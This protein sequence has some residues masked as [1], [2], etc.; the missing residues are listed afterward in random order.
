ME[1]ACHQVDH[2]V[3]KTSSVSQFSIILILLATTFA[4]VSVI[5][6]TQAHL[7]SKI[8]LILSI[9]FGSLAL[10]KLTCSVAASFP[11]PI[12]SFVLWTH[13]MVFEI[14]TFLFIL[15]WIHLLRFYKNYDCPVGTPNGKPILLI[16]GYCNDGTVWAY[17]RN[18]LAK[19]DLGPLYI[20]HLGNPFLSLQGYVD[21][22]LKKCEEIKKMTGKTEVILV[23]HSMGGLIASIS[24]F[25][26]ESIPTVITIASPLAGTRVAKIGIGLSAYQ[27]RLGSEITRDVTQRISKENRIK[28]YHIGAKVDQLIIPS[29]SSLTGLDPT[30][31]FQFEDIGHTALLFSPRVAAVISHWLKTN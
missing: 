24:A 12:R 1:Q 2:K 31:E 10:I 20:I 18:K 6:H 4:A 9:I 19:K 16:H 11:K 27:M 25:Q 26:S 14:F 7:L 8:T 3:E 30:R 13:A 21:C 15:P 29:S 5:A 17:L 22:V 23:G 28:F